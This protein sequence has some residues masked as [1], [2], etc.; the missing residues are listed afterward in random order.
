MGTNKI[1]IEGS[2]PMAVEFYLSYH[3]SQSKTAVDPFPPYDTNLLTAKYMYAEVFHHNIQS[4]SPTDASA[5][6]PLLAYLTAYTT[7]LASGSTVPQA[8]AAGAAAQAAVT[9]DDQAAAATAVTGTFFNPRTLQC[10]LPSAR[11][12]DNFCEAP[13]ELNVDS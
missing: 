2:V 5:A 12:I 7:A 6:A 13:G 1:N 9:A 8:I 10:E 3:F 4:C 11:P